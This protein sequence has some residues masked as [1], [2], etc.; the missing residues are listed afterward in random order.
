MVG[1]WVLDITMLVIPAMSAVFTWP[2][3]TG[4]WRLMRAAWK[5][6][7]GI[8]VYSG[9]TFVVTEAVAVP[10]V[11]VKVAVPAVRV[12]VTVPE[13]ALAVKFVPVQAVW[14]E[15]HVSVKGVPT[16]A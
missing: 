1:L 10:H 13:A 9:R 3:L 6:T 7:S 15:L 5:P 4:T 16:I 12:G 14:L 11:T 8:A 2:A